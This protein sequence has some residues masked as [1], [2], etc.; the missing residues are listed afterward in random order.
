[1]KNKKKYYEIL[2]E[3]KK[4]RYGIFPFTPEGLRDAKKYI[5]ELKAKNDGNFFIKE[6]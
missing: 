6:R 5:E 2:S 1:M 3:Q 4:Y